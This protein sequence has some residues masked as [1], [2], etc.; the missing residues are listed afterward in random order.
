MT[1]MTFGRLFARS[2]VTFSDGGRIADEEPEP[3]HGA[4]TYGTRRHNYSYNLAS[5]YG[6]IIGARPGGS[7]PEVNQG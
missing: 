3:A 2:T 1:T 4:P 7:L 6:P 5:A